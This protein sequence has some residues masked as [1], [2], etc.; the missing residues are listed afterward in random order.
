MSMTRE[1][2]VQGVFDRLAARGQSP[3][4]R[5]ATGTFEFDIDD[6][7]WF[8]KLDHGRPSLVQGDDHPDCVVSCSA[9]DFVEIALGSQ[10]MVTSFM[11]GDVTCQGD[12]A[13][14]LNFRR[15]LPVAA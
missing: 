12:L 6:G 9:S 8:V 7:K 4:L 11:R 14:A 2:T 10:N 1:A 13:F 15:L 5:A 3:G